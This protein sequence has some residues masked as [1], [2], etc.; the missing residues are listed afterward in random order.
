MYALTI[1]KLL[2]INNRQSPKTTIYMYLSHTNTH[3]LY[4]TQSMLRYTLYTLI[5]RTNTCTLLIHSLGTL[6]L[7]VYSDTHLIHSLY[8]QVY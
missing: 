4:A 3:S 7:K 6:I 5:A 2:K 1:N 8:A